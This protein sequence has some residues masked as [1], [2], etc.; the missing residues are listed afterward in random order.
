MQQGT[1]AARRR[2]KA[3][4]LT[5]ADRGHVT[6]ICLTLLGALTITGAAQAQVTPAEEY[7]KRLKIAQTIQPLGE[8]PFGE[9]LNMY[10]G[11]L[12][13]NVVDVQL[14]GNGPTITLARSFG[15]AQEAPLSYYE[16]SNLGNWVLSIPRLETLTGRNTGTLTPIT[17]PG[18]QW[19]V[20]GS[21]PL[22]RC[23]AYGRPLGTPGFSSIWWTGMTLYSEGGAGG[24]LLLKRD[25]LNP[26]QPTMSLNG[27]ALVFPAVT[28]QNWQI[29]CLAA[30]TNGQAGEAFIAVSPEGMRYHLTHLRGT[31][32]D[33]M[34]ED[35][36]GG[37]ILQQHR[38][39]ATMYVS[40]VEDRFGNYV[41][42]N[43]TNDQLTS[44]TASDGRVV[45]LQ[46]RTDM[47]VISTI[48]IPASD[49]PARVWQYEYTLIAP[50]VPRL[51]AV[52]LPD[53]SRW[54]YSTTL[55]SGWTHVGDP[56]YDKLFVKC[57]TRDL[58]AQPER[59]SA[60]ITHPSGLRGRFWSALTFH[61]RS[62][63]PSFCVTPQ[64][65]QEFDPYEGDTPLIGV[66]S[67]TRKEL[68][69]PGIATGLWQ[70]RYVPTWSSTTSDACATAGTC[71]S[72]VSTDVVQPD[73]SRTR[74]TH[75]NRWGETE[76]KLLSIQTF[77]EDADTQPIRTQAMSYAPSSGGL[78]PSKLG[79][80]LTADGNEA[81]NNVYT[82]LRR[83][84]TTQ[85]G[86][87]FTWEVPAVCGPN[88]TTG[89]QLCFSPFA[90]P[91]KVVKT[92]AP[93]P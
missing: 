34:Y 46:W 53:G 68:S 29:G 63:V 36:I 65:G 31:P 55:A 35:T 81:K 2:T 91:T 10:T 49:A 18:N 83:T 89:T 12:T 7:M 42:Y 82:P 78:Y 74:Y 13:F 58:D 39:A 90:M 15:S 41:D 50:D 60:D 61:P 40:K 77:E 75:S 79:N 23:T 17:T 67:L 24:Q 85:Q 22:A 37:V 26:A 3:G 27:T 8:T 33:S 87:N 21:N 70:Y 1:H 92:S 64:I 52:V 44:I 30:T 47:P 88:G 43:Y 76:T 62:Y 32:A 80:S 45:Q 71:P 19:R 11:E 93:T 54:T 59:L 86:R 9:Q 73:G 20:A 56:V 4:N 5:R 38:M 69:G 57:G 48:T 72:T 25:A 14:E 66:Y 51:S 28:Q 84:I 6:G 16:P